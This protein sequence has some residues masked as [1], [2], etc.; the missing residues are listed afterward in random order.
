VGPEKIMPM[1]A[2]FSASG[3]AGEAASSS[4]TAAAVFDES[5]SHSGATSSSVGPIALFLRRRQEAGQNRGWIVGRSVP[6]VAAGIDRRLPML[7]GDND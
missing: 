3:R 2:I 5:A 7:G 1:P 4:A 6:N